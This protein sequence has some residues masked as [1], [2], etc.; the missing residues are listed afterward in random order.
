MLYQEGYTPCQ[1]AEAIGR[2]RSTIYCELKRVQLSSYD[3]QLAQDN[4]TEHKSLKGR[5]LNIRLSS[6]R[7]FEQN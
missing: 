1:I 3:A 6:F 7:I 5:R 2:H 4:A